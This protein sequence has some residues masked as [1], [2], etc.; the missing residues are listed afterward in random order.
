MVI[1]DFQVE[2]KLGRARVFQETFLLANT[3]IKLVLRMLF[4]TFSNVDIK[5]AEKELT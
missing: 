5:F 3:I 2:N 4:L 1:A